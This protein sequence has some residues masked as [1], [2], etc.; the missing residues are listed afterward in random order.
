M[1][2]VELLSPVGNK[3]MLYNAIHN[4][5]DAV[6]LA[7]KKY[8]ARKFAENFTD[9]DLIEAIKYCHLYG[10]K[11]YIT[12]NTLIYENEISDFIE[13]VKFLYCNN[14]DAVIM[15]DIGMIK[16]V[17]NLFPD[18][19]VHA[20]TQCHTHN[21]EC[22]KIFQE[23][24]CQRVVLAREMTL[25]EI[26]S[27]NVDLEKEVFVYG[28]LCVCYSGCCLFSSLNGGRSGNRGECV[29]PCRLP[30]KL[31]K[32]N[33]LIPLPFKYLLSTKDLNTINNL[34]DVLNSNITSL[35]IEGR[36]KSPEYVGYV[37]HIY[38]KLIDKYL[39]KEELIITKEEQTNL[40]KLFNREFTPGYLF[41]NPDIMNIKSPNHQG[42]PIGEVIKITPKYIYLKLTDN[43]YQEDGLRF[44]N[45]NIGLTVNRLY[46]EKGLLIS[47][48]TKGNIYL[49]D[50]KIN[51]TNKDIVLKTID[52]SLI[53]NL[54]NIPEKKIP[55]TFKAV[56]KIGDPLEITISDGINTS[57]ITKD[58]VEKAKK[59]EVTIENI[60]TSLNKLG[61]TPFIAKKIEIEKDSSIFINLKTLNEARRILVD[62][63]IQLRTTKKNNPTIT[64]NYLTSYIS[65]DN[66]IYLN[67]LARTEEQL[68]S[69]IDNQV[70]NIY[71][72]DYE[73]Y[74]K[75]QKYNNI[76]Y[77]I[78]RVNQKYQEFSNA[79]LL[80][81]E[82]G[83]I[84]KYSLNNNLVSDYFLNVTN[85]N[86]IKYLQENHV[87]RVTLSV[88]LSKEQIK[89]IM[90][91][92]YNVELIIYGRLELMITK[93]C[94]LKKCL[95][96][97]S[98]C[99]NSSDSFSL[100]DK[101]G[102]RYPL[103]RKN[104]LTHIMHKEVTNKINDL[105]YYKKLGINNY[106]LELFDEDYQKTTELIKKVKS[107]FHN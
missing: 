33:T 64:N 21:D 15:Q 45:S 98:N 59:H 84:H 52:K 53:K 46:N 83:S 68:Q 69:A 31:I 73:L 96:Y 19:E 7:G 106:R 50:N 71:L 2:K 67:V 36:M 95:N 49:I 66:K 74:Q 20:S 3:E 44:K 58:F 104:C 60:Q 22:L 39:N 41:N 35:K 102:S 93:Y 103:I 86:T 4:G 37:T 9:D 54:K 43:L 99:H 72:D 107:S 56:L 8:G 79:N 101:S 92:P 62:K 81:T 1:Q 75:Y 91:E 6:Y 82:I 63:L 29:G 97:C 32:N 85:S 57:T 17:R 78:P 42:I 61:N 28:A 55:I 18:L 65:H 80:V 23:L 24:G 48:A 10:V 26:N 14:I 88:E 13:Y 12:I 70:S 16:L 30:Y 76:Y 11:I 25:Q 100:E 34:K 89:A 90:K 105:N 87:K 47:K 40:L 94:P 27:L 51:L 38:R 5:A 77:K